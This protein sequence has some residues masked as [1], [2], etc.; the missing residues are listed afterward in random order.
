MSTTAPVRDLLQDRRVSWLWPAALIVV[1]VAWLFLYEPWSTIVAAAGFGVAGGLCVVNATQ[2]RR[3]HCA[4]T[5]P[6]YIVAAVLF[7][8][9]ARGMHLPANW[10]ILGTAVGTVLAFVPEWLGTR[11]LAEIDGASTAATTGALLAAGLAAA[12]CVGPTLFVLAEVA[13][14]GLGSL[15]ALEPYRPLFLLAG[16]ACWGFAYQRQHHA[17]C[18]AEA[19]GTPTTRRMTRA[20][21]WGS[22]VVLMIAAS[23]P[24][25]LVY[26]VG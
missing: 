18:E 14:A 5:G 15:G 13:G 11:Y 17:Q 26:L 2:C 9:R 7:L 21:L 22:L 25:A 1:G 20:L 3:T 16:L 19:C 12:C 4:F 10:I 6:L 8:A 24:Y 23:Y